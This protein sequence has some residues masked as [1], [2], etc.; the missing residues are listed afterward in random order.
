MGS[1]FISVATSGAIIF[2]AVVFGLS[3]RGQASAIA[4]TQ[5][6]AGE[7]L[8]KFTDH[9]QIERLRVDPALDLQTVLAYYRRLPT[10]ASATPNYLVRPST[11]SSG[12][13][14]R[15]T[16]ARRGQLIY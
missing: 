4:P 7:V 13:C 14:S 8:V 6:R 9:P 5:Y 1:R 11:S 10:V 16:L 12:T 2:V 3:V 15:F